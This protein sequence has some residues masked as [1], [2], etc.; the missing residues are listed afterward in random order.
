MGCTA[1]A[2]DLS[3]QVKQHSHCLGRA[4]V[5][6]HSGL[7]ARRVGIAPI[8]VFYPRIA[9]LGHG[10]CGVQALECR[11]GVAQ[12]HVAVVQR[13]AVVRAH[14]KET[15]RFSIKL[16]QHIPDSEK[17]TQT[18]GHFFVI[19]VDEAVVHP[20][21]CQRCAMRTFALRDLVFMVRKLQVSPTAMNVQR[22]AQ[23]GAGHSRAFNV[24][25]RS[26]RAVAA[27]PLRVLGFLGLGGFPQNEIEWV[28]F[29]V[30]HRHA[31]ACVE[32][33]EA[34]AAELAVAREL[35]H[36]KVHVATGCAIGQAFAL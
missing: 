33:V 20:K 15:H 11:A 7:E 27:G 17:I 2:V 6:I 32:L 29:A 8:D 18:F 14:H 35:A 21:T 26:P 36:G 13:A 5:F 22:L 9:A 31:L 16:L 34:F 12:M 19:N 30:L 10:E 3:S 25:A 23:Q 1:A 24:P 28:V 4:K